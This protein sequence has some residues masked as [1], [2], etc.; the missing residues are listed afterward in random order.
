MQS[1]RMRKLRRVR[2][3]VTLALIAI[4]AA[5]FLLQMLD[6]SVTGGWLTATFG[7]TRPAFESG[8]VWT[9]ISHLFLHDPQ[10]WAHILFNML[11][12]WFAGREVER[13]L[14]PK[15]Y[16]I[17]Y[18][19]GGI[20]GGLLQVYTSPP[21]ILLIGASGS[22]FAV[23]L[24]FTTIHANT[25]IT[26]LLFFIFPL[27]VKAKYLGIGLVAASVLL[28]VFAIDQRFGHAAH[29]GGALVGY[30]LSRYWGYGNQ[31]FVERFLGRKKREMSGGWEMMY[32]GRGADERF[33]AILDKISRDGFQSLTPEEKAILDRRNR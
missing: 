20:F 1:V 3:P 15:R 2:S 27:R 24:A 30:L 28:W 26:A 21:G 29:L 6:G 25:V 14:R 19:A 23:L 18:F 22:I 13:V 32:P 12:L 16:L 33:D 10:M 4:N 5:V 8:Q 31:T 17:L 7:L 11:A 9:V